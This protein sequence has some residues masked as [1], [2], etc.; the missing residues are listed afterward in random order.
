MWSGL[1]VEIP[2]GWALCDGTNGTP[3]LVARF[4][5]GINS[6]TTNPG[7]TG[8]ADSVTVVQN[9]HT[10]D[11]PIGDGGGGRFKMKQTYGTGA[12]LGTT[13]RG[14]DPGST[15]ETVT[16]WLSNTRTATNQAHDNR[17]AYFELAYI[18]KL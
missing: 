14:V 15:S 3:N 10:H 4:V 1:L 5:R 16:A 7:G 13:T 9:G 18:M 2:P 11:L 17:P 6:A 12:S 8:G